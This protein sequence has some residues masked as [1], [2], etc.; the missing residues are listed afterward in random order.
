MVDAVQRDAVARELAVHPGSEVLVFGGAEQAARDARLVRDDDQRPARALQRAQ[1][2]H[3]AG[4]PLEVLGAADM[5]SILVQH[6][7]AIQ[8]DGSTHRDHDSS[9]DASRVDARMRSIK[10]VV[11][12]P[13]TKGSATAWP[14]QPRTSALSASLLMS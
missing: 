1:R 9:T 12:K 2:V 3:R 13:S 4:Q 14:P 11:E 5:A 8:E 10:D 7:V 6:A